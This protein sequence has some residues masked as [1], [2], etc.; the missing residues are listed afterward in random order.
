MAARAGSSLPAALTFAPEWE[1][2]EARFAELT[3]QGVDPGALAAGVQGLDFDRPRRPDVLVK[4]S[5]NT[6]TD[7]WA[8]QHRPPTGTPDATRD[9]TAAWARGLDPTSPIDGAAASD[10]VGRYGHDVDAILA[11][12][13]PGLLTTATPMT[14]DDSEARSQQ[15][16]EHRSAHRRKR[17]PH[18]ARRR[19][20]RRKRRHRPGRS[21]RRARTGKP[22]STDAASPRPP[23][24]WSRRAT[25]R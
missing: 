24:S 16:R 17:R 13:Y 11:T 12:T 20:A 19:S 14:G 1:R 8:A 4:W 22:P 7:A 23:A 25:R 5:L 15:A 21:G 10:A 18:P 9:V 3:T 6:T 2:T